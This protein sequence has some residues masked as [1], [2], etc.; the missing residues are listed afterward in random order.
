MALSSISNAAFGFFFWMLAARLYS[1]NDVGIATALISSLNLVA[2]FSRLGFDFSLIRFLPN[3]DRKAVFSTCLSVTMISSAIFGFAFVLSSRFFSPSLSFLQ[4]PVYASVFV[5][6][7]VLS[8]VAFMSGYGFISMRRTENYFFQNLFL[9]SRIPFLIPLA[10]LGFFGIFSAVGFAYL[11]ASIFGLLLIRKFFSFDLRIEKNFVRES[12]RFSSGN[13]L[14]SILSAAPTLILPIMVL[15]LLN[16]AEAAKYYIA[17]SI[18][19]L[20]LV[21]PNSL[22]TSLFVEGSHGESLRKSTFKAF[23]AAFSLLVPSV[24]FIY[25]FGDVLLSFFGKSYLD[26]LDLLK[27][28]AFSS[29]FVCIYS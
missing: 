18:G 19:S 28:L 25:F 9:A 16:E 7:A 1:I 17:F 29:F 10:F 15:N 6:F 3:S 12:L 2:L 8:S 26:A 22:S 23:L 5:F 20:I 21:I 24:I 11:I 13:Y 4:N 14:S 27:L